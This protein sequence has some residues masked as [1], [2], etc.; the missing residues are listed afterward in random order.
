M[1]I[2]KMQKAIP[3][4]TSLLVVSNAM[5]RLSARVTHMQNVTYPYSIIIKKTS[6]YIK[7]QMQRNLEKVEADILDVLKVH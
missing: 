7:T 5:E 2:V 3:H 1:K 4:L 6:V